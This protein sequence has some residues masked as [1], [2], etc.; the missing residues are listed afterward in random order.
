M[1]I[2]LVLQYFT[3]TDYNLKR[4][5]KNCQDKANYFHTQCPGCK[6][7]VKYSIISHSVDK[8][9]HC[10]PLWTWNRGPCYACSITFKLNNT[11]ANI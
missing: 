5:V 4:L 10:T 7:K 6:T 8:I 1:F 11:L 9:S 2:L 3:Q